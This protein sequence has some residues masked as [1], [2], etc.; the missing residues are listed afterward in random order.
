M[1]I[2]YLEPD[3]PYV[4]KQLNGPIIKA[5]IKA[6][7]NFFHTFMDYHAAY[8]KNLSI[9]TADV[10]HLRFIGNIMGLQLFNLFTDASGGMYLVFTDEAFDTDEYDYDNGWAD[11]YRAYQ[12]GDGVFGT[13]NEEE[14]PVTLTTEQYRKI[15]EALSAVR[16]ASVDSI[17]AIDTLAHVFLDSPDYNISYNNGYI[18]VVNIV[19]GPTIGAR[20]TTILQ[21]MY[22][23]L[24][25]GASITVLVSHI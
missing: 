2:E 22:D 4:A 11:A 15:L 5:F 16:S 18:D 9:E 12:E 14:Y 13:G 21:S 7:Y 17:K 23:K 20:Y 19:L 6:V 8:F 3:R 1:A 10:Q 24:F 25:Y